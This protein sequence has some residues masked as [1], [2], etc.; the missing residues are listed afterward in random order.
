MDTATHLVDT[1]VYGSFA[2]FPGPPI[3]EALPIPVCRLSD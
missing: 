1:T 2:H 3:E